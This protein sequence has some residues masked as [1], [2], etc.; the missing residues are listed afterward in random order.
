MKVVSVHG[1]PDN[2][3]IT[4]GFQYIHF[5][6]SFR[7]T[8][9]TTKDID[10]IQR[11]LMK[12]PGWVDFLMNIRN[13]IVRIFGLKTE[14]NE[15]QN[16]YFKCISRNENEIVMGED[17]KH[18]NFRASILTDRKNHYIYLTTAV[19]FNNALGKVYFFFIKPFHKII[20]RS[21]LKRLPG[22]L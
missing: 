13:K 5:F 16:T 21:L 17:D 12:M 4:G 9:Q 10:E 7:I 20:M 14:R 15:E 18:L 19:H 1:I 6:D 11:Q 22:N 2:S 8:L 3:Q